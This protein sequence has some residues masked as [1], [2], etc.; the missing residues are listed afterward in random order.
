G[1]AIDF[2]IEESQ[3]KGDSNEK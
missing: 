3:K 1:T 2:G